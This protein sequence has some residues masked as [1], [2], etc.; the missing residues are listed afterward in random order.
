[1]LFLMHAGCYKHGGTGIMLLESS[2]W[3]CTNQLTAN[4]T[5][6][7]GQCSRTAAASKHLKMRMLAA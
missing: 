4:V 7:R 2:A 3:R 5:D 6:A 1:M